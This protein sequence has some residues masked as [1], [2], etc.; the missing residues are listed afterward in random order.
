MGPLRPE[1][2]A[3]VKIGGGVEVEGEEGQTLK[4][5]IGTTSIRLHNHYYK[6]L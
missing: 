1:R 5:A 4:T 3:T 6:N 2:C